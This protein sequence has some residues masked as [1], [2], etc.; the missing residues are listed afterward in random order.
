ML[1]S[2]CQ[3]ARRPGQAGCGGQ[4][5]PP[6]ARSR[7]G[8]APYRSPGGIGCRVRR[9][10]PPRRHS[11]RLDLK[12]LFAAAATLGHLQPFSGN[13]LAILT[14]GGGIGVLAVDGLMDLHGKLGA[15]NDRRRKVTATSAKMST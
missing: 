10:I 1:V 14:N 11:P 13:R 6:L 7:N 8:A 9:S 3:R 4:D 5:R 12:E 15:I 2:S